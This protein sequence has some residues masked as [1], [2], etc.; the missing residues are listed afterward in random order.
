MSEQLVFDLPVETA[1]GRDDFFTS[2]A[3]AAAVAQIEDWRDWPLGK[4]VLTG[5]EGSGKSHLAR[6]WAAQAGATLANAAD[7]QDADLDRLGET[8]AAVEDV[9]NASAATQEALFLVHNLCAAR[10]A[11]LLLTGRGPAAGWGLTLPD[12]TSRVAAALEVRVGAPDDNLLQAL[13]IKL[14][15]DRQIAVTP[16]VLSQLM[17]HTDRSFAFVEDLVDRLDK[18]ALARKS[19]VNRTVV[20]DVLAQMQRTG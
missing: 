2:E 6:I 3:N 17:L 14:F 13:F 9:P 4:L 5:P 16:A 15:D 12:L 18:A 11:P 20:R 7:L 10:S 8:G 1:F 19:K